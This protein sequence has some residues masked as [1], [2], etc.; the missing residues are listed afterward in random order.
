MT[1]KRQKELALSAATGKDQAQRFNGR[2]LRTQTAAL[3]IGVESVQPSRLGKIFLLL[4]R[5][6]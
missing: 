3:P 6:A 1:S 4:R 2:H 5:P